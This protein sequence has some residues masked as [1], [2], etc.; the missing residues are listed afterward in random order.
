MQGTE[1]SA[2][3]VPPL[4]LQPER[5]AFFLDLDG[6]LVEYASGP[7]AVTIDG[8]LRELLHRLGK[9]SGGAL[10]L[11]SGRSIASLDALLRPLELPVSGMHGFERRSAAGV[12]TRHA[13]PPQETLIEARLHMT[14]IAATDPHL[15]LEDKQFAFALHYRQAPQLENFVLKAVEVI[16][17]LTHGAMQLQRGLLVAELMP[18]G[19]NKA[20]AVAEF[21]SEPPFRGRRPLCVGDDFTDEPAFEWVNAAGG[22]SV[23]VNVRRPTAATTQLRSA[24]EARAWLAQLL[25]A[26]GA[27]S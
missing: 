4:A 26:P 6:T 17:S 10:A 1:H 24:A 15:M 13:A 27:P 11:V 18:C 16:A 8:E 12:Q 19:V 3:A 23:A 7:G 21:M 20:T 5:H 14:Q 2:R 25:E 22:L 9:R